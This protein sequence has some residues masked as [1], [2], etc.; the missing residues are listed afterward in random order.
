MWGRGRG[1]SLGFRGHDLIPPPTDPMA[2]GRLFYLFGLQIP[3]MSCEDQSLG[4]SHRVV[5]RE[6]EREKLAY[7]Q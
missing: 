6:R 5:E 1:Q 7:I 3:H 4:I 2:F